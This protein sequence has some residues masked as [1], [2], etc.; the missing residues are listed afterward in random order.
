MCTYS[1]DMCKQRFLIFSANFYLTAGNIS[2]YHLENNLEV[3]YIST[4]KII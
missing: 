4:L 1:L 2:K 3:K